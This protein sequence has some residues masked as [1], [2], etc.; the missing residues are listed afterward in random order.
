MSDHPVPQRCTSRLQAFACAFQGLRTLWLGQTNARIHSVV[1]VIVTALGLWVR[2]SAMEW[3]VLAL[4]ITV[5]I[6]AEALNT[7]IELVVDLVSPDWHPLARDAKDVAAGAVLIVS[8]GA[9][10]VGLCVFGP[11]LLRG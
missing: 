1:A 9:V 2:L 7:A 10:V 11:H 5:V 3:A 6:A 4:T 8:L